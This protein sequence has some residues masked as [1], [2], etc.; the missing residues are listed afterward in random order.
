[1]KVGTDGVLLGSWAPIRSARKVLDV[2]T[3]C[4]LVALMLAQKMATAGGRISAI[5]IEKD[6]AAQAL[7][8]F[9][10]CPWPE[11]LPT[12]VEDIHVSLQQFA[13]S[14]ADQEF[15]L[16]VCN[17]PFFESAID[18][19]N[20][21]RNTARTTHSLTPNTLFELAR[22]VLK[23]DGRL[24]LILPYTKSDQTIEIAT[25]NGFQLWTRT[26]VRPTPTAELK[27]V[28]FE[29][30]MTKPSGEPDHSELIV[31]EA[32]HQYTRDYEQLTRKFHLRYESND[33]DHSSG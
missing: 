33:T 22:T 18:A 12:C 9:Q 4:G 20:T 21:A 16:V 6:A 32:R 2:G 31:E 1:M 17:P 11:R 23:N 7:E 15:D 24:C 10:A 3:G 19:K 30:G 14:N 26:D 13:E 28:L 25:S 8:N 5:D 29:F 27:R